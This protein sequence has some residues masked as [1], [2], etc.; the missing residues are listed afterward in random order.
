MSKNLSNL[1]NKLTVF[2]IFASRIYIWIRL[3]LRII[4][5]KNNLF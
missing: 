3:E 5:V 1:G 2:D 4:K